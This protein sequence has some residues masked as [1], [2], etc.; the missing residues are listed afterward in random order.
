MTGGKTILLVED[1]E[2]VRHVMREVLVIE[3]YKVLEARGAE[4]GLQLFQQNAGLI[5]L[6]LTDISMPGMN[7]CELAARLE[8]LQPGLRVLLTSGYM[9]IPPSHCG[10]ELPASSYLL[11]PFTTANLVEKVRCVLAAEAPGSAPM[12]S[13]LAGA[14][15]GR[16]RAR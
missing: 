14:D 4:E 12:N 3:G 6:L 8:A 11:K 9:E 10:T 16:A 5:D 15:L 13:H 7:G 1:E 2:F